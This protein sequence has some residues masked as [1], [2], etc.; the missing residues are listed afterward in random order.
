MKNKHIVCIIAALMLPFAIAG[1]AQNEAAPPPV[2]DEIVSPEVPAP[3]LPE[4]PAE[5]RLRK[6]L[7]PKSRP[8]SIR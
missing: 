4:P 8:S 7:C 2:E 1:C 5:C 3:P 6:K